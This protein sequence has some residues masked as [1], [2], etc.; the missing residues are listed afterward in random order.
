MA[1]LSII[2][3]ANRAAGLDLKATLAAATSGG[4]AIPPGPDV[5]LRVV[6]GSGASVTVTAMTAGANAGPS[7]TFLAP[8]PL[9]AVAA[10]GDRLFG[11][12]PAGVFAD[13]SD[14][15]VHVTYSASA[16]VTVGVYRCPN[17]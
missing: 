13:P 1:T 16:S 12:F 11:P 17:S 6:N 9:G 7:G 14:G 4:D 2:G 10:S 5:Y 8:L 15:L 3:A